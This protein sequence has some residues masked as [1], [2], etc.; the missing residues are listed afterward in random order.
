MRLQKRQRADFN[1]GKNVTQ[2]EENKTN[3]YY[4]FNNVPDTLDE[5][6]L[7]LSDR[8]QRDRTSINDSSTFLP[9]DLCTG[10]S[11]YLKCF[12]L[13]LYMADFHFIL[14]FSSQPSLPHKDLV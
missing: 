7:G 9:Q 10:N 14:Y 3:I 2:K 12:C 13:H 5:V 8:V 1:T 6:L 4:V 11:L